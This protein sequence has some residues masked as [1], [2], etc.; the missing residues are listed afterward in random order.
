ME[1]LS[2]N[3][4]LLGIAHSILETVP[5]TTHLSA[6]EILIANVEEAGE[7]QQLSIESLLLI[8]MKN[9]NEKASNSIQTIF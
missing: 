1:K 8:Q 5:V 6:G 4:G 3:S 2:G 7:L 9:S